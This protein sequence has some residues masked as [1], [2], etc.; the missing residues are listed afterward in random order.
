MKQHLRFCLR[1]GL[2]GVLSLSLLILHPAFLPSPAQAG[3][4]Q[5]VLEIISP[6]PPPRTPPGRGK[7]TIGR[8]NS[9]S[10]RSPI[11]LTALVV[12]TKIEGLPSQPDS[13]DITY[14]GGYTTEGYPTLWFYVPYKPSQEK[15]ASNLMLLNREQPSRE[16]TALKLML[17]NYQK[18][19]TL[20]LMLLDEEQNQLFDQPIEFPLNE[21]PGIVGLKLPNQD[22]EGRPISPLQINRQ[23][24]WYLSV[25]CDE[26]RPSRN[27]DVNGWI[28]RVSLQTA[29]E[30]AIWYDR[31]TELAIAYRDGKE[32]I[33]KPQDWETLL[34][35]IGLSD[36]SQLSRQEQLKISFVHC[37]TP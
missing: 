22:K 19:V 21:T 13:P 29:G 1:T 7:G 37:C 31:L 25:V 33:E 16:K 24:A 14:L 3:W 4:L 27:P 6:P 5:R 20:R 9:C 36:I 2:I 30:N 17:L 35:L 28:Q 10:P 8:G 32:K 26:K 23:Y 18:E 34:K 15:V 12:P 11:P